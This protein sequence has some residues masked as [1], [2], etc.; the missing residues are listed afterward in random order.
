MLDKIFIGF[1]YLVPQHLLSRWVGFLADTEIVFIKNL[2]ISV[3]IYAFDI[4][5][6]EAKLPTKEDYKSFNDFFTRE[7][8]D[9]ARTFQTTGILSPADGK[10][11]QF[12][13]ITGG[14]LIQAK[15]IDFTVAEFL[16]SDTTA[17]NAGS[18]ATIYLSPKDYHRVHMPTDGKLI[19]MTYIPGDLFS[20]NK[21]TT[22]NVAG[23][24]ARN[25]RVV[26]LFETANGQMA[27]V[28][29]GAMIVASIETVFA[30]VITPKGPREIT[31][32]NYQN[33][34]EIVLKKGAELGR[35][36]LGST[37]VMLFEKPVDFQTN[38]NDSIQVG[39]ILALD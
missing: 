25:E 31:T 23:L 33:Q 28:L 37:V 14:K 10:I 38:L 36:K 13:A 32:V 18:F 29:V 9:G 7:L 12:G 16:A 20:V 21:A 8:K 39:N 24:F 34:T 6:S 26:C 35:F 22:E 11:S 17:F 27:V 30:G 15:G 19:S 2:L 3:F 1:Q 5:M 4:N